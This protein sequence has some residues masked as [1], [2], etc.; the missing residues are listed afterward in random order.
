MIRCA[1]PLVNLHD[2][3][4]AAIHAAVRHRDLAPRA[5]ERLEMVTATMLGHDLPTIAR[6]RSRD[7]PHLNRK[8]PKWKRLKRMAR[9][10]VA[11]RLELPHIPID[12]SHADT[13]LLGG[14]TM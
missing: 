9:G 5:R 7:R 3:E 4:Q 13:K 1:T 8:E 2:A 11:R 12:G 14:L 6:W 10:Q